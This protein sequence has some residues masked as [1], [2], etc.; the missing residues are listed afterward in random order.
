MIQEHLNLEN[1]ESTNELFKTPDERTLEL[2]AK[3]KELMQS[4]P[5]INDSL[6]ELLSGAANESEA[7]LCIYTIGYL[8][9]YGSGETHGYLKGMV[10]DYVPEA[11]ESS[12]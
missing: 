11:E 1:P 4:N 9:G 10:E 7:L 2:F 3:G 5:K 8:Q 12:K 6:K